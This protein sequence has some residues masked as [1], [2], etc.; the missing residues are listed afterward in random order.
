MEKN[1][2]NRNNWKLKVVGLWR[3]FSL[4]FVIVHLLAPRLHSWTQPS[5]TW[6]IANSLLTRL[7]ASSLVRPQ[8]FL[9]T[10]TLILEIM[11]QILSLFCSKASNGIPSHTGKTRVLTMVYM[12]IS[13]VN[14]TFPSHIISSSTIL[15]SLHSSYTSFLAIPQSSRDAY[16]NIGRFYFMQKSILFFT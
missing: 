7:P 10:T 14:A 8:S 4:N 13:N 15:C 11:S 1:T 2:Y 3:S 9:N 5:L 16:M 12:A 6:M